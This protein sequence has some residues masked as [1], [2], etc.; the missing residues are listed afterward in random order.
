MVRNRIKKAFN[1]E[2]KTWM[3]LTQKR[4]KK[5]GFNEVRER[6]ELEKHIDWLIRYRVLRQGYTAIAREDG[7]AQPA[8]SGRRTV[9]EGIETVTKL[10]GFDSDEPV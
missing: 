3:K 6:P 8:S 2:L 5:L 4:V 1:E 9:T 7:L 10:I